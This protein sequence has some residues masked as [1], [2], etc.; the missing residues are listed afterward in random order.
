MKLFL[1][2]IFLS[3]VTSLFATTIVGN[4]EKI[5]GTVKV[6]S[7]GSIR[8]KR[9]RSGF[10]IQE[11]DLLITSKK[12]SAVLKLLDGSTLVLD[13]SSSIHFHSLTDASQIDGKIYYNITSRDAKNS[14]KIKTPFAIIGIKGTTFVVNATQNASVTLK[15]GLIGVQ[16]IK[17][18]FELYKKAI[19]AEFNNYLSSQMSEF[20][21]F[22]NKQSRYEKPVKTKE[23]D[24]KA[25]NCISFNKKRVN[26]DAWS[27]KDDAEFTHFETLLGTKV[28]KKEEEISK[29]ISLETSEKV[30]EKLENSDDDFGDLDAIENSFYKR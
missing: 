7:E 10:E 15:E 23:F 13:A 12:A 1:V 24:L 19:Q 4:I 25:G 9:V 27:K 17:E 26:E 5:E 8:K 18:E 28:E 16:S 21:K 29:T 2:S 11:G 30:K 14:L 3:I 22:K 6:K 20:E